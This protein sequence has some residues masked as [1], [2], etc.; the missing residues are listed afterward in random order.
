MLNDEQEVQNT[1]RKLERLET[2]YLKRQ[3]E[4][5]GDDD[6]REMTME[7]LAGTIKQFKEEIARYECGIRPKNS[8]GHGGNGSPRLKNDVELAN[9][10]KKLQELEQKLDNGPVESTGDSQVE[11]ISRR[12][13][14]RTINQLK[15]E[16]AR[17]E[18]AHAVRR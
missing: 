12:S 8:S 5:G 17:Y 1:R 18:A 10:R 9:T 16:I 2:L 15:E 4:H 7:S 11:R 13:L 6:L 3:Q 14:K